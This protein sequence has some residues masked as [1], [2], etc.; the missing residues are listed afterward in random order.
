MWKSN[1]ELRNENFSKKK[2]K[3]KKKRDE[4]ELIKN[5]QMNERIKRSEYI[6]AYAA[7]AIAQYYN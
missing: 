7:I 6:T 4:V 5:E 2:R 1:R 3:K